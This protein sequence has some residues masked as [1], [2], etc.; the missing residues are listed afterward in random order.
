MKMK[1]PSQGKHVI[2]KTGKL[3]S[4]FGL[5]WKSVLEDDANDVDFT[6]ANISGV[7]DLSEVVQVTH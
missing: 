5:P 1:H 2:T 3:T 4:A 7:P 6:A